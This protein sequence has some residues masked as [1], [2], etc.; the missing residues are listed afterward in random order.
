MTRHSLAPRG[1][2]PRTPSTWLVLCLLAALLSG[3]ATPARVEQM[4]IEVPAA[5]RGAVVDS[6]LRRQ[7][8]IQSVTG[9]S[10]TNPLWMSKV[11]SADFERALELSLRNAGLLAPDKQSGAYTLSAEM[12]KLDQPLFGASMTVTAMVK[13]TL[14]ERAS[15]REVMQRTLSAAHTAAWNAAFLGT[16]RLKLANEGAVRDNIV[17]LIDALAALKPAPAA[18]PR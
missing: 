1:H 9:G 18:A 3:C 6:A 2:A 11:S 4:Q 5:T 17:Q 10:E 14:L 8:V 12:Y 16:E 7:V 13:Y 15:G